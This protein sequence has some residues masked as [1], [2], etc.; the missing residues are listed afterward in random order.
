MISVLLPVNSASYESQLDRVMKSGT[1]PPFDPLAI[2]FL[3]AV[4]KSVLLD[5]VMRSLPEMAAVAHW[6]RKAHTVELRDD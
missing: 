6:M 3:D 5:N 4:S 2:E 1:L